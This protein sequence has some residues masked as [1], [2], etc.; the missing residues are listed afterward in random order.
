MTGET[1]GGAAAAPG[2]LPHGLEPPL[3]DGPGDGVRDHGVSRGL[4]EW[5]MSIWTTTEC[6]EL[7]VD[8]PL[9]GA[10]HEEGDMELHDLSVGD[11]ELAA[12]QVDVKGDGSAGR[13]G[14]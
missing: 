4:H 6:A 1:G 12:V 5:A 9:L 8:R 3:H 10:L 2:P 11:R 14:E 13:L 7:E